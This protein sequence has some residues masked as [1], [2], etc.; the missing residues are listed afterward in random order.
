[1]KAG[2]LPGA[3]CQREAR[4]LVGLSEP[5]Y[6]KLPEISRV[7]ARGLDPGPFVCG[8][9]AGILIMM[10]ANAWSLKLRLLAADGL[11]LDR[12]GRQEFVTIMAGGATATHNCRGAIKTSAVVEPTMMG[13]ALGAAADQRQAMITS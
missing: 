11:T 4:G 6:F 10:P 7:R 9:P 5:V 1:M 8:W 13:V 3:S 2:R 12:P